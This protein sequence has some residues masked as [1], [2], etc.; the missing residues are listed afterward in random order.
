MT[1]WE[2]VVSTF[3]SVEQSHFRFHSFTNST[4]GSICMNSTHSSLSHELGSERVN[5]RTS[6]WLSTLRV[7][8]I[9]ILSHCPFTP[10]L[11]V[12]KTHG[13]HGSSLNDQR[14]E[15]DGDEIK[16]VIKTNDD[17]F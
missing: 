8:F 14:N 13:G 15:A 16:L 4:V 7:D 2:Q 5:E 9:A 1:V 10:F 6:E 11:P 17:G 3:G 12:A